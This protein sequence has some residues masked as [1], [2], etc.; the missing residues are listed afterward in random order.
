MSV[1][2]DITKLTDTQ[3]DDALLLEELDKKADVGHKHVERDIVDLDRLRYRGEWSDEETYAVNDL[4]VFGKKMYLC[5]ADTDKF[6]PEDGNYW[7]EFLEGV[8][9]ERGPKGE[10]GSKGE[11]G[12]RGPVGMGSEGPAGPAGAA[13][14]AGPAGA[15][16]AA[17]AQGIQGVKG[18]QGIQGIQGI[19]GDPGVTEHRG[20]FTNADL[21]GG[22]LTVTHSKGLGTPSLLLVQVYDNISTMIVPDNVIV[23]ANT[24]QIVLTSWGV[25]SGTWGYIYV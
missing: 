25:I 11:R 5:I 14:A 16:G 15:N 13:G 9:G 6:S 2:N 12:A 18:D 20:T 17:G 4:V 21:V 8:K 22:V 1:R 19:Q 3:M 7:I 10:P 24:F 23:A